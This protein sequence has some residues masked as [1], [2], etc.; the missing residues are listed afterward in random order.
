M[1]YCLISIE[2]FDWLYPPIE[3]SRDFMKFVDHQKNIWIHSI[4]RLLILILQ[5]FLN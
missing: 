3:Y 5:H 1:S 2:P 4:K